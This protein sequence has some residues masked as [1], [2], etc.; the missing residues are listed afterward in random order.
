MVGFEKD[1]FQCC[2][3]LLFTAFVI[4]FSRVVIEL[5]FVPL[6]PGQKKKRKM[7]H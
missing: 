3:W 2:S 4:G 6:Q 7:M 1:L 5:D